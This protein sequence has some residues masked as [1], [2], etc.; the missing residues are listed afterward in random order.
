MVAE[1]K[2]LVASQGGH[3][4]PP[5]ALVD[6]EGRLTG[7][8]E[9]L[10][11]ETLRTPVPNPRAGTGALRTM[12]EHKGSGL[13]L[14]CELLAGALTGNGANAPGERAFGNGMLSIFLDP[15]RLDDTGGAADE[16]ASYVAHV[17]DLPPAQGVESVLIPGDRERRLRRERGENGLTVPAPVLDGI[18]AVAQDDVGRGRRKRPAH[19]CARLALVR[20]ASWN[21]SDSGIRAALTSLATRAAQQHRDDRDTGSSPRDE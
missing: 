15:A 5:D 2:A 8:P 19:G 18:L 16:V 11:G 7:D 17:R 3:P 1:G 20:R 4:L 21:A 12:G 13:A 6:A 14:A 10:Y 9:A